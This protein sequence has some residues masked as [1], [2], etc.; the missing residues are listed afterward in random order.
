MQ[1]WTLSSSWG[2]LL[3]Q[4]APPT[5]LVT[6]QEAPPTLLFT[7]KSYVVMVRLGSTASSVFVWPQRR[8][9]SSM[10]GVETRSLSSRCVC[11]CIPSF[12]ILHVYF[13]DV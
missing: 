2:T 12:Q 9:F 13:L 5:L 4:E 3:V 6:V 1:I 7:G 11:V 8:N 10:S